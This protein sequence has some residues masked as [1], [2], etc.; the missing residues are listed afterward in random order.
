MS[1]LF[2]V[3]QRWLRWSGLLLAI[4][5]FSAVLISRANAETALFDIETVAFSKF[6]TPDTIGPGSTTTLSFSIV[7]P[8]PATLTNLEFT[9]TLPVSVTIATPANA[10]ATC[11]SVL[12]APDG[13]STISFH[14]DRFG[15]YETCIITVDVT[16]SAVGR[17]ENIS[18]QLTSD[19]GEHGNAVASLTVDAGLPGFS[20]SFSPSSIPPGGTSTLIFTIDNIANQVAQSSLRFSDLLPPG[21]V[22]AAL[23]NASTDCTSGSLIADSGTNLI[24]FSSG[25]VAASSS[26]NVAVDVT[27]A[28]FGEYVNISGELTGSGWTSGK[29][30]AVF[31][32]PRKFLIKSFTDDPVAQGDSVTLEFTVTN[33]DRSNPVTDITFSDDLEDTLPGLAAVGLPLADPC[34]AGS[35]L[36]GTSTITLTDGDL[37]AQGSCTFSVTLQV[38]PAASAGVYTNTTSSV[39]AWILGDTA[40]HDPAVDRL[41]VSAA[42]RL[43]KT[44]D[45]PVAAGSTVTLTFTITNTS[46]I[47]G[48]TD[49]S[50]EDIFPVQ[51]PTAAYVPST[52]F[53][54]VESV[55]TFTPLYNPPPPGDTI[56]ANLVV[57][58]ANLAAGDS[59]TFDLVLNVPVDT[60]NGFYVNT[61][62]SIIA[63]VGGTLVE[64]APATD[65]L[66]VVAAPDL[67]KSFDDPV[68]PGDIV[69]LEFTISHD[70][71]APG[72]ATNI[73]FSDDLT[74]LP[75]LAAT[76]L[77]LPDVCGPGSLI[78]GT[79]N[80]DFSGGSLTPGDSCVFSVTLQIPVDAVSGIFENETSNVTADVLGLAT[81]GNPAQD[82]LTVAGLALTKTFVDDPV[83]P[84]DTVILEFSIVNASTVHTAT[85][86][87]FT[88]N[89]ANVLPGTPDITAIDLPNSDVC[90]PGSL[91]DGTTNLNFSGGSLDP[92]TSCT[93]TATLQVPSG[94]ASGTYGNVTTGFRAVID[95]SLVYLE[96]AAD[97]L[98]ISSDWLLFDKSFTDDPVVPGD[99]V[100]LEF[101]ITNLDAAQS[102][103]NV[104]FS[105]DLDAVLSGLVA[106]GLPANDVCGAGSQI[107]G[108]STLALTGGDLGPGGS[109]TFSVDL[110][111]PDGAA[112]GVH[113]NT[114]AE[115]TGT[116]GGLN[117]R[118][119]PAMDDLLV[120]GL[121]FSKSFDDLTVAGGNPVLTFMIQNP[122]T[123]T[124]ANAIEFSDDLDAVILGLV[125]TGLPA[126]DVCGLGSQF[127]GT[128]SLNLRTGSLEPEGSCTFSVTLQVPITATAGNYVNIT[129]D[130]FLGG[131]K[132][133]DPAVA[134]LTVEPPPAFSKSF[135]PDS[136]LLGGI[137]TLG[138]TIDN[139]A[140]ALAASNLDFTDTLPSGVT[141][142]DSPNASTT[143]TDGTI[144][145]VAGTGSVTY[146]G[147]TVDAGA[148]C[149]VQVDVTG[150]A[151]G[152][153]LNITGDLTSSS[154]NSGLASDTLI[155]DPV[156]DLAITKSD[157]PDP[158][159][160]GRT[161]TYT[162]VVTN[163]GPSE[164]TNVYVLDALPDEFTPSGNTCGAS[165]TLWTWNIGSLS[166]N[167]TYTCTI[168]GMVDA[169]FSS[170]ITN[171]A[172][173]ASDVFD[174]QLANDTVTE[175]TWVEGFPSIDTFTLS[176]KPDQLYANG[177]DEA[178]LMVTATNVYGWEDWFAG[179]V[180]T[181]SAS[182]G[183][184]YPVTATLDT[185]GTASIIYTVGLVPGT[186]AVTATVANPGGEK[187]ATT[188]LNLQVN[189]LAGKLVS[190][191]SS[192]LITYTF[193][194]SNVFA[195]LQQGVVLTGT[196]PEGTIFVAA[197]GGISV[198][199][200]A[201]IYVVSPA[202][203]LAYGQRVTLTWTVQVPMSTLGEIVSRA[204]AE[205]LT[206]RLGITSLDSI[207][208]ILLPTKYK[209]AE[210]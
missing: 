52:G 110:L 153:H 70:D 96:N 95:G 92:G 6:F 56:P 23:P 109:C 73:A 210:F 37:P 106:T 45:D 185:N 113:R 186:D 151:V 127:E 136:I 121:T 69:T 62:S 198:A 4:V 143:C 134:P 145:A 90:G 147:G 2:P 67:H 124:V 191:F 154:G 77:P 16:S 81:T 209:N 168:Y 108:T 15:E 178:T 187:I 98:T 161:L 100:T 182:L 131:I 32:A 86:I 74:F 58:D 132:A 195:E 181:F 128:S 173:V 105:D 61:T 162:L 206:A 117:V 140:S 76:N 175:T 202:T 75:D 192:E 93:F 7:N 205:S 141:V 72:D 167:D 176:A 68:I 17:H 190:T 104:A 53:C 1:K 155:V 204:W 194:V 5:L 91:I 34:G 88:D 79:T 174:P 172:T 164:A 63:T 94:A 43:V 80:L 47:S 163:Y 18:G 183:N 85:S 21:M 157:S 114:T 36:I 99:P 97:K 87:A 30:S 44:F 57:S 83:I 20:K 120:S 101:T 66:E 180:V 59:C 188:T 65:Y 189:P 152:T 42:P 22:I 139:T 41:V 19:S 29:A 35:Q 14:A 150:I 10:A 11:D 54:G 193:V 201:Q 199:Q 135:A 142:A 115:I 156:A 197:T 40:I 149:V 46:P 102:V 170:L 130:L 9:D 84:G 28:D 111:S 165:G 49:I 51:L 160:G 78:S 38:P 126:S 166:M 27:V 64:G 137:S 177:L 203:D 196:V 171:T 82:D 50:F 133:S 112:F 107:A 60:P 24:Y 26:C 33:L 169:G 118:G 158:V 55:A 123:D 200:G 13:G 138:F 144:T 25:S 48:V 159:L 129:S 125:A 71:F 8:D 12:V 122:S 179:H 207:Y 31:D 184:L 89:L 103:N 148:S 146:S 3:S 39:S 208:R 116:I 119:D